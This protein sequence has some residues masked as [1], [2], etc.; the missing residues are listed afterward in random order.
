MIV[1]KKPLHLVGLI[2]AHVTPMEVA[3]YIIVPFIK[4]LE[5]GFSIL[6]KNKKQ[7]IT[8][9]GGMHM[10][11]GDHIGQLKLSGIP[12]PRTTYCSRLFNFSFSNIILLS[13]MTVQILYNS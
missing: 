4:D 5:D 7:N 6:D 12:D 2:P 1:K 3:E 9:I 10:I 13:Y 11:G 8:L